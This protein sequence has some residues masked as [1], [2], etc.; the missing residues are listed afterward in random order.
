MIALRSQKHTLFAVQ[1]TPEPISPTMV[2]MRM[3]L[4][5]RLLLM[6]MILWLPVSG[7]MAAVMPF[8]ALTA[9]STSASGMVTT[10]SSMLASMPCHKVSPSNKAALG[11]GCNHCVLCHLAGALMLAS[12][13][14]VPWIAPTHVYAAVPMAAH[15]SFFP[16]RSNPPPRVAL[17]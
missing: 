6:W 12:V 17:A 5:R 7:A 14:A 9:A 1:K 8:A 11:D 3:T 16:E 13:P 4:K 15:P 2:C 10:D